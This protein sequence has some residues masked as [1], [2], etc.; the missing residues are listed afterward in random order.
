MSQFDRCTLS[1]LLLFGC[2]LAL[3]EG[4]Y[5]SRTRAQ[6]LPIVVSVS[7]AVVR[8]GVVRLPAD[9]R[10][11]HAIEVSGGLSAQ[12][13]SEAVELAR[14]LRDGEHLIVPRKTM[15]AARE[16]REVPESLTPVDSRPSP[17]A[18]AKAPAPLADRDLASK[19]RPPRVHEVPTS[20]VDI[21]RASAVQ[22]ES[23]P[24]VGPVLAE[25]IVQARQA[26]PGG[27]FGSLE[28]LGAIRGIKAK[29]FLRLKPYLKIEGS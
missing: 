3:R 12:A 4:D 14:P 27:T 17:E 22:F 13:D 15:A 7:G 18:P 1:L 24:G 10:A 9:A 26:A 6:R 19:A 28:E 29:T 2:L 5:L 8:P 11:V 25:R 23:L 21:N 16:S 20:P